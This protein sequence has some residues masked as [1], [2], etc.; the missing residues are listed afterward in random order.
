M[1]PMFLESTDGWR[2]RKKLLLDTLIVDA[3]A[4]VVLLL[5]Q[6]TLSILL[7]VRFSSIHLRFC[8][9]YSSSLVVQVQYHKSE[10]KRRHGNFFVIAMCTL[11]IN[12]AT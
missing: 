6:A 2:F 7:L 3:H 1:F 10:L 4:V 8:S 11:Y 5:L 12:V 9:C